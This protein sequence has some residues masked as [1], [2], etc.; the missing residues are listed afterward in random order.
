MAKFP[1]PPV[2]PMDPVY[3]KDFMSKNK[4]D[5]DIIKGIV[6]AL[7][8]YNKACNIAVNKLEKA[9]NKLIK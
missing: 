2:R 3:L 1:F 9:L 8:D 5:K 7:N 6:G 4:M